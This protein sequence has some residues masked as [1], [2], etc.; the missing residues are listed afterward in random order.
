[1]Y[2]GH[3]ILYISVQIQV[4]FYIID[5]KEQTKIQQSLGKTFGFS[6]LFQVQLDLLCFVIA[7]TTIQF[8]LDLFSIHNGNSLQGFLSPGELDPLNRRLV[9]EPKPDIVVQGISIHYKS[10]SI[11]SVYS[12]CKLC[13]QTDERLLF[14]LQT[15]LLTF[16]ICVFQNAISSFKIDNNLNICK[17]LRKKINTK[18]R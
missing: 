10:Y 12:T 6:Y 4:Y 1:M 18:E 13:I 17:I 9:S 3:A 2:I 15:S 16:L 5:W 14:F 8:Q 11:I 7:C